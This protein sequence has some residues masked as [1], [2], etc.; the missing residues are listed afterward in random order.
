[1]QIWPPSSPAMYRSG[2]CKS[3]CDS[4]PVS[5]TLQPR[6]RF[7][8]SQLPP[9]SRPGMVRAASP[10]MRSK[11]GVP[12]ST[13]P[14]SAPLGSGSSAVRGRGGDWGWEKGGDEEELQFSGVEVQSG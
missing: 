5:P 1:M 14:S 7:L 4:S 3:V 10:A 6:L 11:S 2:F 12:L 9:F 8:M 13:D